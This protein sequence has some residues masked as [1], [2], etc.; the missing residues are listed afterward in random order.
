VWAAEH[1]NRLASV[2]LIASG[3]LTTYVPHAFA[4]IWGT[5]VLGEINIGTSIRQ[6]FDATFQLLNPRPLPAAFVDRLYDD[7]DRGT[8]CAVLSYY[9]DYGGNLG[10]AAEPRWEGQQAIFSKL[11][12]PALVIW[13]ADDPYIPASQAD[14]Q[15]N[16]FPAA[17]VHVL[18]NS[19]HFPFVDEPDVTR[20]LLVS[21]LRRVATPLPTPAAQATPHHS[22][23]RRARHRSQR[24]RHRHSQ[25]TRRARRPR[26][27]PTRA[28]SPNA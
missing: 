24:Q 5:P 4:V 9:R 19:G 15:K 11:R 18:A 26:S 3:V 6:G 16:S 25:S 12:L 27:S 7:F 17:E 14:N 20:S 28:A 23:S 8:R 21:F 10:G 2:T 1:T 22:R 13:G